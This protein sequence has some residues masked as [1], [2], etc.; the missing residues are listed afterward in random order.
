MKAC[1]G[2]RVGEEGIHIPGRFD[3]EGCCVFHLFHRTLVS[4]TQ[5]NGHFSG[6]HAS[7][8]DWN[9]LGTSM[10]G[11]L[12][13]CQKRRQTTE[14]VGKPMWREETDL[15]CTLRVNRRCRM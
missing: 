15:G 14:S 2:S 11:S 8:R 13:P 6:F 7:S 1:R 9:F 4:P 12:L 10:H 5:T 3:V